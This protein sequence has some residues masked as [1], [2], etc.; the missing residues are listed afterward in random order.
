MNRIYQYQVMI[1]ISM[2]VNRFLSGKHL[3]YQ[4]L[5]YTLHA[6]SALRWQSI[7]FCSG[8][9]LSSQGMQC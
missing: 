8:F 3:H 1:I 4:E 6:S 7:V 2:M 5:D 9:P